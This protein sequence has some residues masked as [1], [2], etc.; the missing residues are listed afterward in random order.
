MDRRTAVLERVDKAML[1][2]N[3]GRA[4]LSGWGWLREP[5]QVRLQRL[6]VQGTRTA[7]KE[8]VVL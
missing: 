3:R 7:M 1:C 4:A 6:K 5:E 8:M 2:C